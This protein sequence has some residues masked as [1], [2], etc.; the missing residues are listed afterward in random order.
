MKR[1]KNILVL[2]DDDGIADNAFDRVSWLAE[3]NGA[4]VTLVD[5]V[6]ENRS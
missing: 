3:A 2:C 4:R 6:D 1:F 5:V